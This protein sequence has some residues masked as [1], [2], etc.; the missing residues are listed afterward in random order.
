MVLFLKKVKLNAHHAA[1][2]L[3]MRTS[4]YNQTGGEPMKNFFD[5]DDGNGW[6]D[7]DGDDEPN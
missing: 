1:K 2:A 7:D 6:D 5:E 3:L 4:R